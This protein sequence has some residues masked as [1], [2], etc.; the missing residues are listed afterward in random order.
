MIFTKGDANEPTL[1]VQV[2]G[3]YM[4]AHKMT[5]EDAVRYADLA[6]EK[7]RERQPRLE[8]VATGTRQ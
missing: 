8:S 2:L 5:P 1:W 7:W 4:N 6:V 3:I